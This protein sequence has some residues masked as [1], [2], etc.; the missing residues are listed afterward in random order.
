[1][2]PE[3]TELSS[4]AFSLWYMHILDIYELEVDGLDEYELGNGWMDRE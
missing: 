1:M 4:G 2:K 3:C